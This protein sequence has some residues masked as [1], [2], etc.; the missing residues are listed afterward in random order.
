MKRKSVDSFSRQALMEMLSEESGLFCSYLK[1][2]VALN[3]LCI[4][5][6]AGIFVSVLLIP[7]FYLEG[8]VFASVL[9]SLLD[10]A[11]IQ[12]GA[13]SYPALALSTAS[14][15]LPN[16]IGLYIFF[17]LLRIFRKIQGGETPFT[18]VS[19]GMWRKISLVYAFFALLSFFSCFI[20]RSVTSIFLILPPMSAYL[21]FHSLELIFLYGTGLQKESDETL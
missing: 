12:S 11:V 3:L 20:L 5:L 17:I 19:A 15:I 10:A 16:L 4:V 9:L 21:F 13:V 14:G 7:D 2:F 8:S 6:Y 1:L 18:S